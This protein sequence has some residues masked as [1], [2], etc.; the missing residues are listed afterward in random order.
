MCGLNGIEIVIFSSLKVYSQYKTNKEAKKEC[1]CE[2]RFNYVKIQ[3]G[4]TFRPNSF[5]YF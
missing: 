4:D 1:I 5:S 3:R 2:I